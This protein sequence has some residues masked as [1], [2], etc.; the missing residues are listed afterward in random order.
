MFLGAVFSSG[1]Y[2]YASA[3]LRT[4]SLKPGFDE[5]SNAAVAFHMPSVVR[6]ACRAYAVSVVRVRGHRRRGRAGVPGQ[7][8]CC[9][10]PGCV[11]SGRPRPTANCSS[12][13]TAS[14]SSAPTTR[15]P[16]PARRQ[17]AK[18]FW[19]GRQVDFADRF[20]ALITAIGLVITG[21]FMYALIAS[22]GE[23]GLHQ[24]AG[25]LAPVRDDR[26]APPPARTRIT[27]VWCGRAGCRRGRCRAPAPT[28]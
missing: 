28:W 23:Q 21:F 16:R 20:L 10:S 5:V 12:R 15:R 7:P 8:V 14:R 3:W 6:D 9:A 25:A 13:P 17:V 24:R 11:R 26:P 4:G 19:W 22:A 2:V 1:F 27:P 18:V